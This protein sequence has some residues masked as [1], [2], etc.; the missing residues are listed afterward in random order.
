MVAAD[1]A[2][3]YYVGETEL[4]DDDIRK[5]AANNT[6]IQLDKARLVATLHESVQTEKGM[7]IVQKNR[8]LPISICRSGVKLNIVPKVWFWPGD[9]PE[10]EKA[11]K[12]Q[13]DI[14]EKMELESRAAAIGLVTA[15]NSDGMRMPPGRR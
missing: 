3:T 7:V 9:D 14:A 11:I 2:T 1:A 4:S 13:I 12:G 6:P 15:T 10:T 5:E 8:V